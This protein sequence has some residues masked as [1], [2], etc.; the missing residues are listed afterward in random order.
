MKIFVDDHGP[1]VI[2]L[3]EHKLSSRHRFELEGYDVFRQDRQSRGG[4][5]AV[6]VR[7]SF[8]SERIHIRTGGI[9][10]CAA[11]VFTRDG[12]S[13]AF[14]SLYLRP[15]EPLIPSDL[16]SI[17]ELHE[18]GEVVVG[19]DLNAKHPS[20]GGTEVDPRGRRL[21]RFL[22]DYP[23]FAT[24]RCDRPTRPNA[25]GGTYI[26][27]FLLTPGVPLT[28]D[29]G[30]SRAFDFESD[31]RA[32]QVT[33][34]IGRLEIRNPRTFLDFSR[35][36]VRRYRARL[37]EG[38]SPISL[39]VDRNVTTQEIDDCVEGLGMVFRSAIEASVPRVP[40]E[41]TRMFLPGWIL[42]LI[43]ER[44]AL[45]RALRGS[46]DPERRGLL[47]TD[48]RH[49]SRVI[50]ES[51][52][53][54]ERDRMSRR[55]G[56]IRI[57]GR[58]YS[59]VK[60]AAGLSN[61][62]PIGDLTSSDGSVL[63][64]DLSK[65]EALADHVQ[66]DLVTG[67]PPSDGE[68]ERQVHEVADDLVDASP[69]VEFSGSFPANG[70]AV[71]DRSLWEDG[72]FVKPSC[73]GSALSSWSSKRS[74]GVDRVPD[75]AL[76]RAGN[77]I[78]TFLCV[79]FNHCLN[80]GYFPPAWKTAVVVPIP[81]PGSDRRDRSGYRPVSLLS[82]FGRLFESF[83]LRRIARVVE[84]RG[85]LPDGQFGF[86][87]DHSTTHALGVFTSYV[88][89]GFD[90]K[91]GTIAVGLD[92]SKAFD[93]VWHDG[94]LF[95]LRGLGFGRQV[96][97][98]VASFL[99]GRSFCVRVGEQ[100]SSD[101]PVRSGVPQ[102]SILGPMLY[103]LFV[104]DIPTPPSGGMLLAYADDVM[105]AF[106]GPRASIVNRNVNMFLGELCGY[107][108][109]WRLRLNPAKC[110]AMVFRGRTGTTYPNF[111]RYV[112]VVRIGVDDV[113]ITGTIKY[114]GVVFD[115]RLEFRNH[116]DY[117]LDRARRV[118][119]GYHRLFR[120]RRGLSSAVKLLI[121]R[122]VIRPVVSYAFPIWF[123]IS[124]AQME[125]VRAWERRALRSCLG[126]RTIVR[127]DGSVS[128]PSCRAIYDGAGTPRIDVWMVRGAIEFLGR[129]GD[130]GNGMV[131]DHFS[132]NDD[133]NALLNRTY[134]SPAALPRLNEENLLYDGE[135]LLFYHRRHNSFDFQD[136]VYDTTQ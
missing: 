115:S 130:V 63:T 36:H 98:V 82:T 6:L 44:R 112:P 67:F 15:G 59:Q 57:D 132:S 85:I 88:A 45:C 120:M 91:Y 13:V 5:T 48:I 92:I 133:R 119:F 17:M 31:H 9:E 81:K 117:A 60:R 83:I 127:R 124:S 102:G 84:D 108:T 22:L 1:D 100:S 111:R 7:S 39:P 110:S 8:R 129:C 106:S 43:Y 123:G 21:A 118:Y 29:G 23:D 70:T 46:A 96:C 97:R 50:R 24:C 116:V 12:G 105:L 136:T 114:L 27:F 121:Y 80:L 99:H 25:S 94:L 72:L 126:L 90:R 58:S 37:G 19:A 33:L 101:R 26:D 16:E 113:A 2:L 38:L 103:N 4:G 104:H 95:K 86:R 77:V 107:F 134:F 20:W 135:V 65:A 32:I 52:D 62:E 54:F 125:R 76:K 18:S 93:S 40:V 68:F 14:V 61:R 47:R 71:A 73:I 28:G 11:R 78:F 79:L 122:Q 66:V 42:R 131:S 69:L 89:R 128:R 30:L 10:S 74:S 75:I 64:D 51:I 53:S 49:L 87:P 34:G 3:A 35:M 41:R 55:L 109:R 56:R